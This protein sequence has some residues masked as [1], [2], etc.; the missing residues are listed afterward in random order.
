MIEKVFATLVYPGVIFVVVY[1]FF[2]QGIARKLVARMQNRVGPPIL[3]P[4]YDVIK[5]VGKENIHFRYSSQM[6]WI[7]LAFVSAFSA[8]L[9][10]PAVLSH[11]NLLYNGAN[12]ILVAYFLGFSYV[13]M[14][15]SGIASRSVYGEIGG[16][17]GIAQFVSFEIVFLL[18]VFIPAIKL[19]SFDLM[20]IASMGSKMIMELPLFAVAFVLSILPQV[21]LQP[22]NIP[23]A[24]QEIVAGY[25][26]EFSGIS[27]ALTEMTHWLK[28]FALISLFGTLYLG[29]IKSFPAFFIY[30]VL[31]LFILVLIRTAIARARINTMNKI[32]MV[33][34]FILLANMVVWNV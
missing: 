4:F 2:L 31:M 33:L 9:V 12:L 27:Y 1:S 15:F 29:G 5:L 3:Q 10:V 7:V 19:G 14:A 32:Y 20:E 22:F 24:H 8:S 25:A 16:A 34:A 23:N 13:A 18:A 11:N 28:L 30:S 21:N 6:M 17:R 26:T